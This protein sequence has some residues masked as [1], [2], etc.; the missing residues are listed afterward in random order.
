MRIKQLMIVV[1]CV[2]IALGLISCKEERKIVGTWE[3]VKTQEVLVIKNHPN[4]KY[5]VTR[6]TTTYPEA[7]ESFIL[8]FTKKGVVLAQETDSHG[9]TDSDSFPYM[10][11]DNKL[12]VES[13]EYA[14]S[15]KGKEMTL[16]N[17]KTYTLTYDNTEYQR[18]E[19]EV[20]TLKER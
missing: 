15:I 10:I 19:K 18:Y 20:M 16:T 14:F 9:N 2:G 11:M 3:L 13:M 7:G 4:A 6:D 17:E 12:Y 8:T 1:A 5:N